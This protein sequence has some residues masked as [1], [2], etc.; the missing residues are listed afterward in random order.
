[1]NKMRR[2]ILIYEYVLCHS[3]VFFTGMC[4]FR[5]LTQM[6]AL[7]STLGYLKV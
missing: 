3:D 5:V 2:F 6:A 1:M 4:I 7:C